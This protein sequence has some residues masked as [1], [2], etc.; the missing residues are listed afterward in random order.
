MLLANKRVLVVVVVTGAVALGVFACRGGEAEE[1]LA[2]SSAPA[3]AGSG[4]EAAALSDG[5]AGGPA[6]GG[7]ESEPPS[8][9]ALSAL[10]DAAAASD[11][12]ANPEPS[13][14]DA[15]GGSADGPAASAAADVSTDGPFDAASQAAAL[16]AQAA[17]TLAELNEGIGTSPVSDSPPSPPPP[18]VPAP[19][20]CKTIDQDALAKSFDGAMDAFSALQDALWQEGSA[21]QAK[22]AATVQTAT[23]K[24]GAYR[25]LVAEVA[26]KLPD[27]A[28]LG[29]LVAELPSG[30]GP[31]PAKARYP[32]LGLIFGAAFDGVPAAAEDPQRE[33]ASPLRMAPDRLATTDDGLSA[34]HAT[35]LAMLDVIRWLSIAAGDI[36]DQVA[37][38]CATPVP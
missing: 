21:A 23:T 14:D 7:N 37:A 33:G 19:A 1:P 18:A 2:T 36:T 20:A 3:S 11:T 12:A 6:T 8:D 26:G 9:A 17:A 22:I 38:T 24:Y 15:H 29:S 25:K 16:R 34:A 5:A 35:G 10:P 27:D 30:Q 32:L 28:R 4:A 13:S 31:S